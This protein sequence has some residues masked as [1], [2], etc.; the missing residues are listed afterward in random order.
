MYS[1][2]IPLAKY[3]LSYN[4]L[5][6]DSQNNVVFGNVFLEENWSDFKLW[7]FVGSL[8]CAK[9]VVKLSKKLL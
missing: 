2:L 8:F 3:S 1:N 6:V 5:L 9:Y 4:N 7:N